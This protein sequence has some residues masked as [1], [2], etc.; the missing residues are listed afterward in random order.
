MQDNAKIILCQV[1]LKFLSGYQISNLKH[2]I[3]NKSKML[4]SNDQNNDL[5]IQKH[6]PEFTCLVPYGK[7]T[8]KFVCI[9]KF[10]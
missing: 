2:Q 3:T 5:G 9:F 1:L 10:G 8:R 6:Y 4:I 7:T